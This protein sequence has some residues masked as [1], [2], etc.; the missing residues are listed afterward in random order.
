MSDP[1]AL[2][3]QLWNH[4]PQMKAEFAKRKLKW[5]EMASQDLADILVYLRNLPDTQKSV[6]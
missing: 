4:V 5:P 2:V 3:D 6:R 1:I